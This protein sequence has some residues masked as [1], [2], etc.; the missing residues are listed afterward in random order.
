MRQARGQGQLAGGPILARMA[1]VTRLPPLVEAVLEVTD[2]IPRGQVL[3][4]GDVAGYAGQGGPRQVGRV[5]AEYGSLT[6]WWR[7]IR[8]DG[9]LPRGHESE[10]HRRLRAEGVPMRGGRVDMRRA[11][12]P[13]PRSGAVGGR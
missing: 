8:A 10:A 4:Y 5:M 7:V 11:R 9:S 13:G 1:D 2:A 3:S 12:W 6:R